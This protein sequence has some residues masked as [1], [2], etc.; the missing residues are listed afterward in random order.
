MAHATYRLLTFSELNGWAED[1]HAAAL[2]VFRN[3]ADLL[4]P[5]W[6]D[7]VA[8]LDG[9]HDPRVY[10]ETHFTPFEISDSSPALF[11]GYFEPEL[12]GSLTTD[13]T[14][15]HPLYRMPDGELPTRAEIEDGALDGRDLELVWLADPVEAFFLHIQGSGR[16]ALPGGGTLRVGYAGKNG[17][18]YQSVGK[19]LI[20]AG[21][22]DPTEI[23][24][25]RIK[26]WMRANPTDAKE[27]MRKNQSYVFFRELDVP[28]ESGPIGVMGR[29]VT[30]GRTIAVDPGF[31]IYGA[32]VWIEKDAPDA[33]SRLMIAQDTGAAIK[34]AQRADIFV[35]TGEKAGHIAGGYQ[36]SGR[37]VALLPRK[38]AEG[39]V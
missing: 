38:L 13:D 27:L 7:C 35:G 22:I 3:T 37:M 14:Y 10:F 30:A 20:D 34:G 12:L 1:D 17:Y 36:Q 32:P 6:A 39:L 31:N 11:T 4:G 21:K 33:M 26:D 19:K 29:S 23:S 5:D 25:E 28:L 18:L 15:R 16:V 2:S 9:V 24:A 8:A